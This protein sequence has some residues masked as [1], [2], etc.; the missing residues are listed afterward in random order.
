M[1]RVGAQLARPRPG[2]TLSLLEWG[3]M[4]T[5]VIRLVLVLASSAVAASGMAQGLDPRLGGTVHFGSQPGI[6]QDF[7]T[8]EW[9]QPIGA[10]QR[11]VTFMDWHGIVNEE[12]FLGQNFGGGYRMY[13]PR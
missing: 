9:F 13:M 11:D 5:H 2:T 6:D 4:R 10:T 12:G 8:F 1:R 3:L 7:T